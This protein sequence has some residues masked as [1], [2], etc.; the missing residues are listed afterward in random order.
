MISKNECVLI[1]HMILLHCISSHGLV[2]GHCHSF[3]LKRFS[4]RQQAA[5]RI[6]FFFFFPKGDCPN[7]PPTST[8]PSAKKMDI[9]YNIEVKLAD[10]W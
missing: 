9:L 7:V 6:T 3:Y 2:L 8:P 5:P 4:T 10:I 1:F